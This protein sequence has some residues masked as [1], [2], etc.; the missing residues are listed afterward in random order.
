[1]IKSL[2]KRPD[3]RY[4]S[5]AEFFDDLQHLQRGE[6]TSVKT[7]PLLPASDSGRMATF[8]F[9]WELSCSP[10][11]LWPFVSNTERLNRAI[12]LPSVEFSIRR[13]ESGDRQRFAEFRFAGMRMQWQEHMFEWIEAQRL[14][15]LREFQRGPLRWL[16]SV[17][18]LHRRADGGTTLTHSFNANCR[19]LP[20]LLFAKF[21]M[22]VVTRRAL[23]RVYRRIDAVVGNHPQ[24]DTL[25]D[26]F[27]ESRS[28]K[29]RSSVLLERIVDRLSQRQLNRTTLLKVT[30]YVRTAA[31]QDVSHIRPRALARKLNLAAEA[32]VDVCLHGVHEGLFELSWDVICPS[33]RIATQ[34]QDAIE[35]IRKHVRCEACDFDFEVDFGTSVEMIARVSPQIRQPD[36]GQYCIGGP[37]HSPHVV[38]QARVAA[39]ET[40][41]LGLEL[42]EGRYVLRGPQL[43][44]SISLNVTNA[45]QQDRLFVDLALSVV[46]P[47]SI[48]LRTE[49]QLITFANNGSSEIL[50]R[51]ERSTIP[52]DAITALQAAGMPFFRRSFANQMPTAEQVVGTQHLTF[53]VVTTHSTESLTNR[54]GELRSCDL[55]KSHLDLLVE[56]ATRFGGSLV[57]PIE[58][59]GLLVFR[60]LDSAIQAV[61]SIDET[62]P[63]LNG[64]AAWQPVIAIHQGLVMMTTINGQIEYLGSALRVVRM[65][66]AAGRPGEIAATPDLEARLVSA[67]FEPV[68]P[69]QSCDG[70]QI[71]HPVAE[72]TVM[73]FRRA[74]T[75]Q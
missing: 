9:S 18:D 70:P 31:V 17:V 22:Q 21:Q 52:D 28:L 15:V 67:G 36:T 12:N 59:G 33:C 66:A 13:I 37:A 55:L 34:S 32:M 40:V 29:R 2:Q 53:V 41:N 68:A 38:A 19:H 10:E 14:S 61:Y 54:Y 26:A 16:T 6:A 71:I 47:S 39:N 57:R 4:R 25:V 50:L 74:E 35:N 58:E 24:S 1:M 60:N 65:L 51:I 62:I 20:G 23:D 64:V 49:R 75:I 46:R 72:S 73:Q 3:L 45:A 48:D 7:H 5:A 11:E 42:S 27:E 30:D 44:F 56:L 63:V 8:S 69:H 43:P